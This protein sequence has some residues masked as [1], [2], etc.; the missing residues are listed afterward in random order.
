M[1][2]IEKAAV[3]DGFSSIQ[4]IRRS[5]QESP[6]ARTRP[7]SSRLPAHD[8][9]G[10][11]QSSEQR[12]KARIGHTAL[13]TRHEIVCY[14]CG[15]EH[16]ITGRI[17]NP[18]CPKCHEELETGDVVVDTE[19]DRCIKTVGTV[20]VKQG[21]ALRHANVI[22]SR[23]VLA[24]EIESS[25]VNIGGRLD[26]RKGARLDLQEIKYR[27]LFVA[28]DAKFSY[29]KKITCRDLTVEGELR[30]KVHTT[31]VARI[32]AGGLLRGEIHGEHLIVDDG[33][34]LKAKVFVGATGGEQRGTGD[35]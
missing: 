23:L 4:A 9:D 18:F 21:A 22:A 25:V 2:S 11:T 10:A 17:H 16:T 30:A 32:R 28:G 5:G 26:I 31:G 33:G 34:G 1:G 6:E 12:A 3:I 35:S 19:T 7:S 13:P 27:D 24:G 15:Y 8:A 20:E 29:R 14:E